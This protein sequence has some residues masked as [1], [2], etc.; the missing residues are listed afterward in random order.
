MTFIYFCS[1]S[2]LSLFENQI[3]LQNTFLEFQS[4]QI[5]LWNDNLESIKIKNENIYYL[6]F[7]N[8]YIFN[9]NQQII[10]KYTIV[11]PLH[12]IFT[13]YLNDTYCT[14]YYIENEIISTNS[15]NMDINS[16]WLENLIKLKKNLL[17]LIIK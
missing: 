1:K 12:M 4:Q 8:Y 17:C 10:G 5:I 11:S 9:S 13:V 7:M 2:N 14:I 15:I 3:S 6:L 16:K